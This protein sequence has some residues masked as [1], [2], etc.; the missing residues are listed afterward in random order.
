MMGPL[1]YSSASPL[2]M[3][4]F[5]YTLPLLGDGATELYPASALLMGPLSYILFLLW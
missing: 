1:S 4:P 3:G 5:N 2:L